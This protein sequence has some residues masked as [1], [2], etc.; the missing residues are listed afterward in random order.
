MNEDTGTEDAAAS[1]SMVDIYIKTDIK[2]YVYRKLLQIFMLFVI[3]KSHLCRHCL[4][5]NFS[6]PYISVTIG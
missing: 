6:L 1:D 5:C 3:E 4:T 2:S